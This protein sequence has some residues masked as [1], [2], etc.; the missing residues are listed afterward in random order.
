MATASVSLSQTNQLKC[1]TAYFIA[2][3]N[4]EWR[5]KFHFPARR[6]PDL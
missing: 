3:Q 5:S 2:L 6:M 4:A 1:V